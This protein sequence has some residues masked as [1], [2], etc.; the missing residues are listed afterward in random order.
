LKRQNRKER[1]QE[2]RENRQERREDR[3]LLPLGLGVAGTGLALYACLEAFRNKGRIDDNEDRHQENAITLA[4]NAV[5]ITANNAV[6]VANATAIAEKAA[7]F[8]EWKGKRENGRQQASGSLRPLYSNYAPDATTLD[9]MFTHGD[10]TNGTI[11]KNTIAAYIQWYGLEYKSDGLPNSV[12]NPITKSQ[13]VESGT[14][15]V[16]EAGGGPSTSFANLKRLIYPNSGIVTAVANIVWEL[17]D[18]KGIFAGYTQCSIDY[19]QTS[20]LNDT[21]K[22]RK[23]TFTG[24]GLPAITMFYNVFDRRNAGS[25]GRIDSYISN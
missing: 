25:I 6:G 12:T 1:R 2:R 13:F 3:N 20:K 9:T 4:T 10:V 7:E 11:T 22:E 21:A 5:K 17:S 8:D 19:A 16:E 15:F 23:L 24:P 18:Q 14:L